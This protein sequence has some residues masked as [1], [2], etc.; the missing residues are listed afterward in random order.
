MIWYDIRYDIW[1]MIWYDIWYYMWYDIYDM[2]YDMI[3]Y[4]M[5]YDMIWYMIWYIIYDMIYDVIWYMIWYDMIYDMIWYD[6]IYMIWY[7]IYVIWYTIWYDMI[8]LLTA[9]GLTPG[10]S[11]TVHI[12]TQT[13]HRTTQSTQTMHRTTQLI[14]WEECGPCP[15]FV[16]CTLPFALQLKKKARKT[17]SQSSRVYTEMSNTWWQFSVKLCLKQLRK[18]VNTA[19][20]LFK[21]TRN[22]ILELSIAFKYFENRQ[23]C[24]KFI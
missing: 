8:Y 11:S 6:M 20:M 23:T 5:I 4:Y 12:Y 7:M 2:I 13:I 22:I 19:D 15:V 14:N 24:N 17:L 10:G 16:S 1:Y 18:T 21:Y 9:I 3:W